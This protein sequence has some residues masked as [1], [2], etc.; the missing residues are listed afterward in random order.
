MLK[1]RLELLE[2]RIAIDQETV[3][4]LYLRIA[5][6]VSSNHD[7]QF[8]DYLKEELHNNIHERDLIQQL[9]N[10]GKE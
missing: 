1:E 5:I 7:K 8:H 6:G 9:I 10:E 3:A 4:R 2:K